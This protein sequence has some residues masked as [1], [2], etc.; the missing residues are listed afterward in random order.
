VNLRKKFQ[1]AFILLAVTA[2]A[3]L[4]ML[5]ILMQIENREYLERH[6]GE[7]IQLNYPV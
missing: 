3:V 7:A 5:G 1:I 2:A 6:Q 4:V